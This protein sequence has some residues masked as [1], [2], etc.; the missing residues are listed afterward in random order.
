VIEGRRLWSDCA[1]EVKHKQDAGA[2]QVRERPCTQAE[3]LFDPDDFEGRT[4]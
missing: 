1:Y 2:R 4:A 3:R